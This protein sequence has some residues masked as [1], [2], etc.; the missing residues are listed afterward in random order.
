MAVCR[1]PW[2]LNFVVSVGVN[3]LQTEEETLVLFVA[4]AFVGH[5]VGYGIA[6]PEVDAIV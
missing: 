4:V 6:D 1:G 3:T 5:G 2:R